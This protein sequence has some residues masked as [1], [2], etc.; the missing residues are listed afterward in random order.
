MVEEAAVLLKEQ[1]RK[2]NLATKVTVPKKIDSPEP[3]STAIKWV[4]GQGGNQCCQQGVVMPLKKWFFQRGKAINTWKKTFLKIG[5]FFTNLLFLPK[6]GH[7]CGPRISTTLN[8]TQH[9]RQIIL[10]L[11]SQSGAGIAAR[12][13]I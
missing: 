1:T 4:G 12:R 5:D 11:T 3:G 13:K 9:K 2:K 7:L 10:K 8:M 6:V